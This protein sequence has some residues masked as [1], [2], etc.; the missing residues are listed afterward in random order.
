MEI[1]KILHLRCTL[2]WSKDKKDYP[3]LLFYLDRSYN[4]EVVKWICTKNVD[5]KSKEKFYLDY[6]WKNL[7][8]IS[9]FNKEHLVYMVVRIY[10]L[11]EEI[12]PRKFQQFIIPIN[13]DTIKNS[14]VLLKIIKKIHCN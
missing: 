4:S 9:Y 12:Y 7:N 2:K 8:P 1:K 5:L 10:K 13:S 14:I 6:H 11:E 3:L